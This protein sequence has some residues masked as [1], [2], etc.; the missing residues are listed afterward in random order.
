MGTPCVSST[1]SVSGKSKI[2]FAPEH[3]TATGV[4]P[5][6][7]KSA[8][9]SNGAPRCTPPIPPVEKTRIPAMCAMIIVPATVV[10][11]SSASPTAIGK[12]RR[13]HFRTV[14]DGS[15]ASRSMS[16][17]ARPTVIFPPST[18][19]VAGTAP[20]SRT[21]ASIASAVSTF[22]GYG[23]PCVMSVDSRA[24]TGRPAARAAAT[25]EE[26]MMGS[27]IF[28]KARRPLPSP[29]T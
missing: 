20:L 19:I 24:T 6:S 3:T 11:A 12:S 15:A 1:S 10:A 4:R 21:A 14:P 7:S 25:S 18:A 28:Q 2:D 13:E 16:A 5:S 27:V 17:R 23:R 22:A 8:D 26:R 9:T 29:R